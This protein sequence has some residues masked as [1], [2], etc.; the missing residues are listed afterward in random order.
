MITKAQSAAE[1]AQIE[2]NAAADRVISSD[3]I[4][5]DICALLHVLTDKRLSNLIEIV[6]LE[7][8]ERESDRIIDSTAMKA[9]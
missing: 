2:R 4:F 9:R 5:D 1:A 7:Q 6:R 8:V 3:A